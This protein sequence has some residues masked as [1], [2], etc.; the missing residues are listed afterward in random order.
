M[1]RVI[2][3]LD[4]DAFFCSVEAQFNPDLH[5]KAFAV[6]GQ[7]DARGVVAS[8]SYAA[9][10]H[11]VRSAMPMSKALRL[12]PG[13]IIVPPHFDRYQAA[14]SAVM[15]ILADM[16]PLVQQLSIDEAFMDLTGLPGSAQDIARRIQTEIRQATG[17]P[18][19]LGAATNKLVAKIATNVGKS[20]A[21]TDDTPNAITVVPPGT[22]SAFLAPLPVRDLWGV[23]P[24]TAEQLALLDV[25]TIG[26]LAQIPEAEL[27]FRFGKLGT[28]LYHRARGLDDRPVEPDRETKSI[29]HETTFAQDVSSREELRLTLRR[30][31][32]DV[33]RRLRR[34][35]LS[36]T[37]VRLKLR[38]SDFTTISRQMTATAP[39]DQDAAIYAAALELLDTA[40]MVGRSVRLIGVGVSGLRES[41]HQLDLWDVQADQQQ[42][43]LQST[44]DEL[45][46]R[47]GPASL[48]RGSDLNND[49]H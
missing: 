8:C 15:A 24:K 11:G 18:S 16:T 45:R 40:W 17:L 49:D 38:W 10:R 25:N 42:R 20:Q 28:E 23:G 37:T 47:Y 6:G 48:M 7:P 5:Q 36:G 12:C 13:L 19:S 43:R 22:E 41:V 44:L 27:R 34:E 21:V 26:D 31:S 35:G 1:K 32:E 14:S 9:R 29:S 30:L 4:L 33:G 39:L 2:I 46:E 3:H